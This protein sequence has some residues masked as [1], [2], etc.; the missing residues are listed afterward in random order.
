MPSWP[1]VSMRTRVYELIAVGFTIVQASLVFFTPVGQTPPLAE[2]IGISVLLLSLSMVLWVVVRLHGWLETQSWIG[3]L[4]IGAAALRAWALLPLT[5]LMPEPPQMLLPRTQLIVLAGAYAVA[6]AG[7]TGTAL[8]VT[9]RRDAL[10][11]AGL[12][13]FG[14]VIV[15]ALFYLASFG[16]LP[17]MPTVLTARDKLAMFM[18]AG[19]LLLLAISSFVMLKALDRPGGTMAR[20]WLWISVGMLILAMGDSVQP[21]LAIRDAAEFSALLWGLGYAMV[22]A[23]ASIIVDVVDAQGPDVAPGGVPAIDRRTS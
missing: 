18:L 17:G 2:Y 4:L 11:P 8:L 3:I 21:L 22:G 23:G 13:V 16:P 9:Q 6:A 12:A 20:P 10:R 14:A 19:D 1:N 15:G 5:Y 7:F